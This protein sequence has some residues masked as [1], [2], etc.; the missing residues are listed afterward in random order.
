MDYELIVVG[1]GPAGLSAALTGACYKL[2]TLVIDAASAGGAPINNFPWKVVDNVLG[3]RNMNGKQVADVFVEHVKKEGVVVKENEGVENITR[4]NVADKILVETNKN[5]YTAKAVIITIGILGKPRKANVKGENLNG[6]NYTV[7]DPNLYT[8][9]KVLVV[10]GGDTAVEWAV[11]LDK[12]GAKTT[13]IH[14]K[15]VF[16]ANEKNQKDIVE[17]DVK[18]LWNTEIK[19]ILG[20]NKVEGAIL[21]NNQ[22]NE[23]ITE[24]FDEILADMCDAKAIIIGSPTYFANVPAKL[25]DLMDKTIILRR[26]GRK[27]KNK[28]GGAISVGGS[29]NGGQEYVILAIHNFMLVHEMIVVGD[30]DTAHFGGIAIARNLGDVLNDK[31]G[32]ETC[33]NL[34]KRIVEVLKGVKI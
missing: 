10:G 8:K 30:K 32:L 34:A 2:K 21:M 4:D 13:I 26:H 7:T 16:R 20:E 11:G 9:K 17:S 29:R 18:I 6:V 14:R 22:T 12:A 23:T 27:L 3:F 5:K 28:I 24:N 25:K 19:E 15:N 33:E 1:G 31:D